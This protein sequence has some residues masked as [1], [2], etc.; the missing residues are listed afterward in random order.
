MLFLLKIENQVKGS[1]TLAQV[2]ALEDAGFING[3]TLTCH[4]GMEDWTPWS[5]FNKD[6]GL[7]EPTEGIVTPPVEA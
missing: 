7:I 1:Y 6:D 2:R 5:M 3:E 4:E